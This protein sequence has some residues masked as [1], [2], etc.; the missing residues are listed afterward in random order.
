[1][2]QSAVDVQFVTDAQTCAKLSWACRRTTTDGS[3]GG[4][5]RVD[6]IGEAA[7]RRVVRGI[8][9]IPSRSLISTF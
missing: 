3:N 5:W 6:Y 7:L 1:M 8:S 4:I 9:C 2:R